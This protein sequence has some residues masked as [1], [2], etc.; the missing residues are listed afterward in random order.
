MS[1]SI[2]QKILNPST[3]VIGFMAELNRQI[4]F[5][6]ANF[7]S[8]QYATSSAAK[9]SGKPFIVGIIPPDN[10][11][12]FV[13]FDA[14]R[15][16]L[17]D[18]KS[19]TNA[20]VSDSSIK[21][22]IA[23]ANNDLPFTKEQIQ[24]RVADGTTGPANDQIVNTSKKI[25]GEAL[26]TLER[27][28]FYDALLTV[29][30]RNNLR[31]EDILVILCGE[32]KLGS[33][34]SNSEARGIFQMLKSE[35]NKV[36]PGTAN[37]FE[38]MSAVEQLTYYDAYINN[39]KPFTGGKNLGALELYLMN[40]GKVGL[41]NN[42]NANGTQV[43][44]DKNYEINKPLDHNGNGVI[45][46]EDMK[47]HIDKIR[48]EPAYQLTMAALSSHI[49]NEET[50]E[51]TGL[52]GIT[53]NE[54]RTLMVYGGVTQQEGDDATWRVG[55]RIS[56][57]S[58]QRIL[59]VQKQTSALQNQINTLNS[60]PPLLL[61]VNPS[62]FSR[63]YEH[64]TDSSVKGRYG[65]IVNLW[66]ER[67]MKISGSGMSA[68]Q[69][70]MDLVGNGGLTTENR[71]HSLSYQN[72]MSLFMIYKNN[73]VLFAGSE[74]QAGIPIVTCSLYIYYD[75]HIYIGSFSDFSIDDDASKPFNMKYS[76]TFDV[77]YDMDI[78]SSL[79]IE[80]KISR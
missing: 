13:P 4:N 76:F 1:D 5:N 65:N 25:N 75:N 52:T 77:R 55:N 74:S 34:A 47:T 16:D 39:L 14:K 56:K 7:E 78:D 63:S 37:S 32:S 62:E 50:T 31:P 36:A 29:S 6:I 42:T 15:K 12:N 30:K 10:T 72:L 53:G 80:T 38:K 22:A 61:L 66:L 3:S 73:G 24:Q 70:A 20:T 26:S 51:P 45:D 44:D 40:A 58:E 27:T 21:Q 48:R 59:E 60:M 49:A 46:M 69:Y 9:R 19:Q 35:I 11:V 2:F 79:L 28:G 43:V 54:K 67:P 8:E 23:K 71:V 41:I 68:G 57:A 64:T 18:L 33:T 17:W